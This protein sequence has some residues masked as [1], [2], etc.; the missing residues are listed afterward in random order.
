VPVDGLASVL[1]TEHH[2]G[3]KSALIF[4]ERDTVERVRLSSS[5]SL[6]IV[7]IPP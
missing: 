7:R 3:T 5:S 6:F 2:E 1:V 4:M